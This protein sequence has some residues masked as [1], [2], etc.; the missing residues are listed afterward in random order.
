MR[1]LIAFATAIGI[2]L[3]LFWGMQAMIGTDSRELARRDPAP[4]VDFVRVQPAQTAPR[5]RQRQR[6]ERP[7]E[8]PPPP[9][10]VPQAAASPA[11]IPEP[12]NLAAPAFTPQLA[13]GEL[14]TLGA[15]TAGTPS[16]VEH[17]EGELMPVSQVPPQ[18][19]QRALN[20]G[21]EG[22]VGS[23]SSSPKT[24]RCAMSR[25]SKPTLARAFSITPPDAL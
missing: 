24:A 12:L 10:P 3:G 1:Y 21:L 9:P 15:P 6:P 11:I 23:V 8:A 14:P 18:Y 17:Y 16:G 5:E 4:A 13:L 20:Q 2:A 22:W 7:T 19:P 25:S